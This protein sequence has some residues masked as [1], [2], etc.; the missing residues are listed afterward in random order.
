MV[1]TIRKFKSDFT[2]LDSLVPCM[3]G[4]KKYNGSTN[5]ASKQDIMKILFHWITI[6]LPGSS[7][8]FLHDPLW[9]SG[10]T[11]DLP[12]LRVSL[13]LY[14]PSEYKGDEYLY[15]EDDFSKFE[16]SAFPPKKPPCCFSP[17]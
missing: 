5:K 16:L 10:Y 6:S 11:L 14:L 12:N 15:P 3:M 17:E 1:T 2:Q 9:S 13:T 7:I 4:K 8:R